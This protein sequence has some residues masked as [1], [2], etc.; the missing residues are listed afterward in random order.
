MKANYDLPHFYKDNLSEEQFTEVVKIESQ[1][2][3][4]GHHID[5]SYSKG[6]LIIARE[7]H[8][9]ICMDKAILLLF[10]IKPN[11]TNNEIRK[12][13]LKYRKLQDSMETIRNIYNKAKVSGYSFLFLIFS[14]SSHISYY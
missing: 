7:H 6:I 3:K 9:S 1:N 14:I 12:Q 8:E 11:M 13:Y 4:E 2:L 10:K 5:V